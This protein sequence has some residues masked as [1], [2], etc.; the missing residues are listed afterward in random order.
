MPLTES[1][2]SSLLSTCYEILQFDTESSEEDYEKVSSYSPMEY[3]S[4][5]WELERQTADSPQL[6]CIGS[7]EYKAK[8][9]SY[10]LVVKQP[11]SV[12]DKVSI[13]Y[14]KLPD[15]IISAN[16]VSISY[17]E[18]VRES[19][20]QISR[21]ELEPIDESFLTQTEKDLLP[22]M[23]SLTEMVEDKVC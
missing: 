22:H 3:S 14:S 1:S 13:E 20:E 15:E 9:S 19:I 7:K 10:S 5:V 11:E 2:I 6:E 21:Y 12:D 4:D 17:L 18:S 16:T 23:S 8:D